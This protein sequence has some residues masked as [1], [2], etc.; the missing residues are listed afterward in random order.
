[1]GSTDAFNPKARPLV[2]LCVSLMSVAPAAW[3][4][5]GPL[6]VP[7]T[8]F[9][10]NVV[11]PVPE[12]GFG[13]ETPVEPVGDNMGTTVGQ[14]R[15]EVYKHAVAQWQRELEIDNR[16]VVQAA[17]VPLSC[18]TNSAVLGAAGA[19]SASR[20]F[21]GPAFPAT[22]YSAA[23]ANELAETDIMGD[24][25]DP[26]LLAPPF[27]DEIVS[28]FN[29]A[30]GTAD[31]LVAGGWY[32]GLDGN[33]PPGSVDFL[34]TLMH[35][36]GHG[37]GFQ[38]FADPETGR[39]LQ[40]LPDQWSRF[41]RDGT[42][43]K[44]WDQMTDLEREFSAVNSQN[45]VWAGPAVTASAPLALN[46]ATV[47]QVAEPAS[48]EGVQLPFAAAVFSAALPAS[49]MSGPVSLVNDGI[50]VPA[51]GCEPIYQD[52]AGQF[53]LIDRGG[54]DFVTK[55]ANAQA[56]NAAAVIIANNVTSAKPIALGGATPVDI[57]VVSVTRGAGQLL[58]LSPNTEVLLGAPASDGAVAGVDSNGFVS[59]HAPA[60]PEPGASVAH[61]DAT[62]ASGLLM[63]PVAGES[64]GL[65]SATDIDLTGDLLRDIGWDGNINCP[66]DSRLQP[67]VSLLE[68][69][70]TGVAN[71]RGAFTILPA[72][73]W[74]PPGYGGSVAG[75]CSI[76]DVVDACRPVIR[77]ADGGTRYHACVTDVADTLV[78]QGHLSQDEAGLITA[79]SAMIVP[80]LDAP[81]D[82]P[83]PGATAP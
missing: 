30:L 41:L 3:A 43:S 53:A 74:L 6:D 77:L 38:G 73:S 52:L 61:F 18:D 83:S 76:Q 81:V 75:G 57:P 69:C 49:A 23:L 58:R 29:S 36:L 17:F 24:L 37:L 50:G 10:I 13:D 56:A 26:G 70:P 66:A 45:L 59:L 65:A 40:G 39:N 47:I 79:C 33:N 64:R 78:G 20:D 46:P 1:M 25:P 62:A 68:I 7:G 8:N 48:L 72:E 19:I 80:V 60:R 31:C 34:R 71:Y 5:N 51:D 63:S 54:C 22:W 27:N 32:Y 15:L 67:S 21:G 12:L 14:Q 42:L 9:V 44:H 4:E 55:A 2:V 16:V 28:L 82:E 35:E 11:D